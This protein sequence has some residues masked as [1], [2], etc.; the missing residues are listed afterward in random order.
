MAIE[1]P[2]V[3]GTIMTE[4]EA[5]SIDIIPE[6]ERTGRVRSQFTLW[7]ATNANVF[8][9]VL[10]GFAILF[11][12]NLFWALVALFVGTFLGM[13]FT[14][15]HAVQG[16][17]RADGVGA[18]RCG[19][20]LARRLCR[21]RCRLP[22]VEPARPRSGAA[23]GRGRHG[24]LAWKLTSDRNREW[25]GSGARP[26]VDIAARGRRGRRPTSRH[27]QPEAAGQAW[28]ARAESGVHGQREREHGGSIALAQQ[29]RTD[30]HRPAGAD[31]VIDQ[32]HRLAEPGERGAQV[33]GHGQGAP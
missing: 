14:A 26:R 11:G 1:H 25:R 29:L 20:F 27:G 30:G 15:L 10:G 2:Q 19:H 8:N 9:F 7:F 4:I 18:R 5:H 17:R 32:Q 12:L 6:N 22:G 3:G 21:G 28:P 33:A 16:P 13:A 24:H 31:A 23:A